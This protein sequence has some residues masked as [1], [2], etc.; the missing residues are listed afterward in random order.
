LIVARP[1]Q[2]LKSLP[3]KARQL[4]PARVKK[5][6]KEKAKMERKVQ[7]L[8]KPLSELTKDWTHVPIGDIETF[9]NRSAEERRQ[10]VEDSKIPGKVK[11]PMNSFML[12]R[13]AYQNR[14]KEYHLQNNHQVVSTVCGES[15]HIEPEEIRNQYNEWARIERTNHQNAHPGYKFS[16][17]KAGQK[18]AKG[19]MPEDVDIEESDLE[20]YDWQ[21]GQ[22][23]NI[24]PKRPNPR[25]ERH[26]QYDI[27]R[28][29]YDR[30]RDQSL[31]PTYDGIN[32][33][34][35]QATNPGKPPPAQY[36]QDNLRNGQYYEQIIHQ[37]VVVPGIEDVVIRK[38]AAPGTGMNYLGLPGEGYGLMDQQYQRFE[39]ITP[40]EHRIDPSLLAQDQRVLYN[41]QYIEQEAPYLADNELQ[42]ST[43]WQP[44]YAGFDPDDPLTYLEGTQQ[45][46]DCS[47]QIPGQQLH[48]LKGVEDG[49]QMVDSLEASQEFDTW[50][51]DH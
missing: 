7:R 28:A 9:V 2:G 1:P 36:S 17:S 31:E 8:E 20:D 43:P 45:F 41:D 12:Y 24:K 39:E 27:N 23:K 30:S 4:K 33:S 19:Q 50:M 48:L 49:W 21:R 29:L 5:T 14:T 38:T 51:D 3:E 44:I 11:R 40:P 35:Y 16:P 47:L 46:D 13:K 10:E 32:R 42:D 25:I 22:R 15:W 34:S 37:H 18:P 26:V 6:R